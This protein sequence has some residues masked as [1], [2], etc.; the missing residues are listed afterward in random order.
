MGRNGVIRRVVIIIVTMTVGL[1]ATITSK[2]EKN[3]ITTTNISDN[4]DIVKGREHLIELEQ[5][6]FN[7]IEDKIQKKLD[8]QKKSL[9]VKQREV[10]KNI[11]FKKYYENTIFMGD[12]ITEAIKVY[13][14]LKDSSV[15]AKKGEDVVKAKEHVSQL[16]SMKPNKVVLL[17]GMNDVE[18]FN[19]PNDF[20]KNYLS[21]VNEIKT[22]LP[23][24]KIYLQSPLPVTDAAINESPRVTNANLKEFR[25]VVYDISKETNV[26]YVDITPIAEA[27][28]NLYEGDGIHFKYGFY[29]KWLNYLYNTME[30][31]V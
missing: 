5:L 30:E 4:S 24:A 19:N 11:N 6:D 12:S 15:L 16:V 7:Q 17:Y 26:N 23:K 9:L 8:E 14:V 13:E 29:N 25:K 22:K 27:N 1:S 20:K 10:D 18:T 31:V 21:L 3:N 2:A 28:V